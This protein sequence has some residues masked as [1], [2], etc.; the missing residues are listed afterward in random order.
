MPNSGGSIFDF[1]GILTVFFLV[2]A[3]GFLLQ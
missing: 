2:G 1:V 3:N